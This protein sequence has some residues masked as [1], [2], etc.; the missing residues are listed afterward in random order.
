MTQESTSGIPELET[1]TYELLKR[2]ALT[3]GTQTKVE[4]QGYDIWARKFITFPEA[5]QYE[6]SWTLESLQLS[7]KLVLLDSPQTL[8]THMQVELDVQEK[9]DNDEEKR[10]YVFHVNYHADPPVVNRLETVQQHAKAAT[11]EEADWRAKIDAERDPAKPGSR[12]QRY[13]ARDSSTEAALQEREF[14]LYLLEQ[15][16]EVIK[17]QKV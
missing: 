4:R 3:F 15:A 7:Y 11:Q 8:M 13:P 6:V 17:Q 12:F 14:S 1:K 5:T 9:L 10:S 16:E 2:L